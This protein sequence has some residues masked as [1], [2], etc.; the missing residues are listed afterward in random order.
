M[1]A[2]P[3]GRVTVAFLVGSLDRG[4]AE[5]Q[6]LELANRLDRARFRPVL[7]TW[8]ARGSLVAELQPDIAN[9]HLSI[10]QV[11]A[12]PAWRRPAVA[13]RLAWRLWRVLRRL[14]PAIL[15]AYLF[16]AYVIGA[17]VGP[18]AGVPVV[19]AGRRGL[20]TYDRFG[21]A[22]A[23]LG[24]IA[25]R[26]I[27]LHICNSDAMR[28]RALEAEPGLDPRRVLVVP[29]G[30]V[31]APDLPGGLPDGWRAPGVVLGAMVA[32]L[33]PHKG[34]AE[35]L[36]ALRQARERGAAVRL[37][38]LGEGPQRPRIEAAIR[39]LGL[40]TSVV[41]AGSRPDVRGLLGHFDFALLASHD[42]SLPNALMEAM[43]AGLPVVATGVGGVGELVRDGIDGWVVPPRD[44]QALAAA[45]VEVAR[46]AERP[47]RGRRGRDSVLR[48]FSMEAMVTATEAAYTRALEQ[49]GAGGAG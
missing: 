41:L 16:T 19:I 48:R 4:G 2:R 26:R 3:S 34:H 37:V 24:R 5:R 23:V 1:T 46:S 33:L 35:A 9:F 45:L 12:V 18:P 29:N 20:S 30:I 25:N 13:A 8:F 10:P 49:A 39:D 14:R 22:A 11:G 42:E 40:A 31:P 21:R 17:L 32:N 43:A 7:I 27:A 15:H 38:L 36:E 44:P 47:E 6:L 28:A